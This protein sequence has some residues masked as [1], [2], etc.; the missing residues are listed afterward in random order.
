MSNATHGQLVQINVNPRG[1]VPKY[2]VPSAE[3]T[4]NGVVGDLQRDRRVH[5]GPERAVC[6]YALERIEALR[7]EGHMIGPGTTGEN[8]T[9][10]G[11]D[12]ARLGIGTRLLIGEW[13]ELEVTD[14]AAPC[15][16]I[17]DSFRDGEFKRISAKLHPGWS[18]LYARVL[19][20]GVVR[21]GDRV[22]CL[23]NPE[24]GLPPA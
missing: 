22:V 5:G 20:E 13:V 16:T 19:S 18:R 8:L 2:A 15:S 11:L 21:V 12:W 24:P 1:G 6:L 4:I 7:G 14:F 17:A 3:L 10:A 23:L 9:L